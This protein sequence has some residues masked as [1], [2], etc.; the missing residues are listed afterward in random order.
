MFATW[1]ISI[2][3]GIL[4]TGNKSD[5]NSESLFQDIE[6]LLE[7][8]RALVN[9]GLIVDGVSFW[10]RF[11]SAH[12]NWVIVFR[13]D[14]VNW[15]WLR[16]KEKW[17]SQVNETIF[18]ILESSI[19]LNELVDLSRN[20]TSDHGSCGGNSWDDLTGNLFSLMSNVCFDLIVDSSQI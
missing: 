4:T 8:K 5:V 3:N 14:F 12:G 11:D 17:E 16:E 20:C 6:Q 13:A 19:S 1:K 18:N 2:V 15:V 7:G 9:D 10:D